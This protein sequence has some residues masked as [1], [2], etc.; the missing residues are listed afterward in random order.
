MARD[1]SAHTPA[2]RIQP[3]LGR[4]MQYKGDWENKRC[5]RGLRSTA[6]TPVRVRHAAG[7]DRHQAGHRDGFPRPNVRMTRSI[8]RAT[9]IHAVCM[10]KESMDRA[11]AFERF[12][13]A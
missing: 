6:R 12:F 3:A 8:K 4:T 1:G 13:L 9:A 5:R 2:A 7:K 11:A 10:K